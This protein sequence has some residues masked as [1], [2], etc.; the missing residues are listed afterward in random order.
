MSITELNEILLQESLFIEKKVN[1]S[2]NLYYLY[3]FQ[4]KNELLYRYRNTIIQY[5]D[6]KGFN[7]EEAPRQHDGTCP[8][9]I[10]IKH[11]IYDPIND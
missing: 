9:E 4:Q 8:I 3:Y 10:T 11:I 5:L 2:S 7:V 1:D 6:R